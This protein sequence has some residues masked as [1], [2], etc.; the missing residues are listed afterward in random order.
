MSPQTKPR[1]RALYVLMGLNVI[2]VGLLVVGIYRVE[3]LHHRLNQA[4]QR[5]FEGCLR[6]NVLREGYRFAMK[7]LGSPERAAQ[8]EVRAQPCALIYPG[9]SK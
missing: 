9:G 2:L 5:N 4:E 6:G 3:S 7:E 1:F 8:P